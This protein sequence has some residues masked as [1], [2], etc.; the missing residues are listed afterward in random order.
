MPSGDKAVGAS[1]PEVQTIRLK[2][3]SGV[4]TQPIPHFI[5]IRLHD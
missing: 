5:A 4:N 2:A 1:V 3:I